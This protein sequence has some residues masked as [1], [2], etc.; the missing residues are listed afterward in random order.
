MNL[1]THCSKVLLFAAT[2]TESL[3]VMHTYAA[4]TQYGASGPFGT[5]TL[6]KN[7]QACGKTPHNIG[8]G[9]GANG[10]Y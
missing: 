7:F 8:G 3:P 2:S 6:D 1:V 10:I 4:Q 5:A 9:D